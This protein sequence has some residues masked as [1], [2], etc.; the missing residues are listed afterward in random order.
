ME[1]LD[2]IVEI[3][4]K[5]VLQQA[6]EKPIEHDPLKILEK[7]QAL[8]T[9]DEIELTSMAYSQ[10][11]SALPVVLFDEIEKRLEGA[12]QSKDGDQVGSSQDGEEGKEQN[13][14]SRVAQTAH[15]LAIFDA[16]NEALDQERPYKFKGLPNP[17]SK[18]TRMTHETLSAQQVDQIIGRARARVIEWD[19]TGAGTKFA[20][21]PPPPPLQSEYDPPHLQ[22]AQQ[23]SEDDR[24]KAE[25]QERLGLLL[26][27]EV[28]QREQDW[29]DYEI[30]DT[31]ARFDLADMILEELAGEVA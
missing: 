4:D 2:F 18:Q 30:E 15:H 16:F 20:P 21:A 29:L 22:Q 31:Q 25:R 12:H 10:Q 3:V 1:H 27:K 6:L 14:V 24:N 8:D 5:E 11:Q 9:E 19:K 7:I 26:T 23:E 17:W 13:N 28:H